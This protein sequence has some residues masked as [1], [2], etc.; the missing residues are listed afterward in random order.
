MIHD[1]FICEVLHTSRFEFGLGPCICLDD[2]TREES[3]GKYKTK[4]NLATNCQLKT[5]NGQSELVRNWLKTLID[6][7]DWWIG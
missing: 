4:R 2:T 7:G 1:L 6:Q 5:E 3:E